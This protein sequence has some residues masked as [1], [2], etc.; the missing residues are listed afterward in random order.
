MWLF[1]KLNKE[2]LFDSHAHIISSDYTSEDYNFIINQA[3]SQSIEYIIDMGVDINTSRE[4]INLSKN[5]P[6]KIFSFVGIDPEVF[7]FGSNMFLGF[8]KDESWLNEQKNSILKMVK[9]NSQVVIGIGETGM[10]F[11][12]FKD[13]DNSIKTKS[14]ELQERLFRLHLEIA[15]EKSLP[16][17]IHSRF[18]EDYCLRIINDYDVSG[19]FHSYTGN[20]E[21]A[22]EVLDAGWGLGVN[23]IITFKNAEELRSVYKKIL[24]KIPHDVTPSYFYDRGIYFETDS[25]YLSPEGKRGEIN[26]PENLRIVYEAFC[27]M[28]K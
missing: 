27:K 21:V 7:I 26:K 4:S 15:Q 9:N 20:Y 1:P 13:H 6:G 18:A 2:L 10:D 8:E 5:F 24:G 25:P 14:R 17:S 23:G 22:K 16:L 19:I 28:V 12:H 11:Y 3:N